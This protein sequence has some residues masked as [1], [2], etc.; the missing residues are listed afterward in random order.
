[1]LVEMNKS[2]RKLVTRACEVCDWSGASVDSGD[3]PGADD[4]P[5]CHAPTRTLRE[6]V[7]M[8]VD[9]RRAQAAALGRA[10]G[11]KGGR[12]R[13]Q[14]LSAKRRV[15]IARKAAAARWRRRGKH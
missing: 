2:S 4:C 1:M 12:I 9:E 13:A 10:G 3:G 7:V 14:R 11:L 5:I 6:E 15:E 8:D